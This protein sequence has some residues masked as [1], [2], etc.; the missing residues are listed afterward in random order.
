MKRNVKMKKEEEGR[1]WRDQRQEER[2]REEN[3]RHALIS[4]YLL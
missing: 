4:S 2:E 1:E 3:L